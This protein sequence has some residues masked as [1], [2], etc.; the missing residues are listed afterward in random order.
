MNQGTSRSLSNPVQLACV[1]LLILLHAYPFLVGGSAISIWSAIALTLITLEHG[2]WLRRLPVISAWS[3]TAIAIAFHWSPAAMAYTLASDYWLGLLT[4]APLIIWDG[5]RLALG[6]WIGSRLTR[7]SQVLWLTTACTSVILELLMP[8][9]FPWKLGYAQLDIPWTIQAVDLFGPSWSTVFAFAVGGVIA[10]IVSMGLH[11]AWE[12]SA[13]N[14]DGISSVTTPE[15]YNSNVSRRSSHWR[16][17]AA[18]VVLM[19]C[20]YSFFSYRSWQAAADEAPHIQAALIQVDPS[21][22]GSTQQAQS[23]TR[24]L[25]PEV[26]LVCWPESSGGNYAFD[27]TD[28]SDDQRVFAL[29]REPERGLR[30]WPKPFCDLLVGGKCYE[31]DPENPAR[32]FVTAMLINTNERIVGRYHKRFLMPFGEYVPGENTVPGLA[33]LFDMAEHVEPGAASEPIVTSSGV[34]VG[35]ALCYEDMVPSASRSVVRNGAQLLISLIN[36]SAFE[37]PLTLIQHRMLA[38]QRA[39]EC[40]RTMLRCAATGET[41]MIDPCGEIVSSLPLQHSG[42]MEVSAAILDRSPPGLSWNWLLPA[43]CIGIMGSFL[44]FGPGKALTANAE[45]PHDN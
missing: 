43:G 28:L 32:L 44:C 45:V 21:F 2:T 35:A 41:C 42:S 14:T 33:A 11:L 7:D 10:R 1:P 38:Q 13:S 8:G 31:G 40:R 19:S 4:A 24:S 12:H 23:L 26:D 3:I 5:M 30:P 36:G 27:L 20:V 22:V 16:W 29:S 9:V 18:I 17:T 37:N 6:Y 39:I 15:A 34:R 25:S